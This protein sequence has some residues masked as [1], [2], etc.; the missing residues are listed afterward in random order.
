MFLLK[1]ML[2]AVSCVVEGSRT[3]RQSRRYQLGLEVLGVE[4]IRRVCLQSF[5]AFLLLE[6]VLVAFRLSHRQSQSRQVNT[7]IDC[8]I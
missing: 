8:S 3:L 5:D 6:T 2:L 4:K 1:Q 7:L